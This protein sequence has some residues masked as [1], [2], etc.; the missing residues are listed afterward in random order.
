[1]GW[2]LAWLATSHGT[3]DFGKRNWHGWN[4]SNQISSHGGCVLPKE[5]MW[6]CTGV[7]PQGDSLPRALKWRM[8]GTQS[9][10]TFRT[11][12]K[13]RV[14]SQQEN[15]PSILISA[16]I[17]NELWRSQTPDE[18]GAGQY[19][20]FRLE[21]RAETV[22]VTHGLLTYRLD[23]ILNLIFRKII[24]C[25]L[26]TRILF[27][28]SDYIFLLLI[29]L[30]KPIF[31]TLGIK[32]DENYWK[33]HQNIEKKESKLVLSLTRSVKRLFLIYLQKQGS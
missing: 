3:V 12:E 18:K 16:D 25:I 21:T 24:F 4:W 10:V 19:L 1:M 29:N 30:T 31:I 14:G 11:R 2:S 9:A 32:K 17:L 27:I 13:P 22:V 8:H 23:P 26:S 5:E 28:V 7:G 6:S 15:G 20:D 33:P